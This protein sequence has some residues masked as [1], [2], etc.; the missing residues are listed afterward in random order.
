MK[1]GQKIIIIIEWYSSILVFINLAIFRSAMRDLILRSF[2]IVLSTNYTQS[3]HSY[4]YTASILEH[5]L[6]YII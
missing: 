5:K 4:T 1:H 2:M 3:Y 6:N